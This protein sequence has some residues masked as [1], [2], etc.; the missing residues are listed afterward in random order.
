MVDQLTRK[1]QRKVAL[2]GDRAA[3]LTGTHWV[4]SG[5][6]EADIAAFARTAAPTL[7]AAKTSAVVT[8]VAY[9]ALRAKIRPPSVN[10]RDVSVDVFHREPFI[11]YWQAL[12]NGHPIEDAIQSGIA[13]AGA[14]ATNLVVSSARRA[15]DVTYRK[16]GLH[17][18]Y[19]NRETDAGACPWCEDVA[20]QTY[21]SAETAD[22]GHDRCGCTPV[23]IF[24]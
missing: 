22:F 2:I 15:G 7:A 8:G 23:P 5:H 6:D 14:L 9:Y 3:R 1:F 10:A 12:K 19:W 11:A 18:I 16:S 21:T 20:D 24:A 4:N 13:R 17:V